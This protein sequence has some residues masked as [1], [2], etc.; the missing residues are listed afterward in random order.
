MKLLA[1]LFLTCSLLYSIEGVKN[2]NINSM[3]SDDVLKA[4]SKRLDSINL[5]VLEQNQKYDKHSAS[6]DKLRTDVSNILLAQKKLRVS[7]KKLKS[8]VHEYNGAEVK[9]KKKMDEIYSLNSQ[10][11]RTTYYVLSHKIDEEYLPSFKNYIVSKYS[12]EKFDQETEIKESTTG[13]MSYKNIVTTKKDFGQMQV[14]TLKDFTYRDIGLNIKVLKVVQSSFVKTSD[15]SLIKSVEKSVNLFEMENSTQIVELESL[16][17]IKTGILGKLQ[18]K[19]SDAKKIVSYLHTTF[20]ISKLNSNKDKSSVK[21]NK[22]LSKIEKAHDKYI[23]GLNRLSGEINSLTSQ[24]E[25]E[26]VSLALKLESANEIAKTYNIDLNTNELEKLIVLTPKVFSESVAI[27]E[28]KEFIQR[29][30]KSYLSKVNISELQQSET[31][32]NMYDLSTKNLSKQKLIEYKSIHFLPFLKGQELSVLVFGVI[33]LE[34]NIS[35]DD[36]VVKDLQYTSLEFVPV[37][38]GFKTIFASTTEVNL[39]IVKEFLETN[40]FHKYFDSYCLEDSFLPEEVKDFRDIGEEYFDYPAVCFKPEMVEEF[41]EWMSERLDKKIVL[42]SSEDWSYVAS[43]ANSSK[44][45]WG[46]ESLNEL[47]LEE[48]QPENIYYENGENTSITPVKQFSKSRIG[49]YDMCGN[50]HELVKDNGIIAIKGNSYISY[51]EESTA[52]AM[53]YEDG[54]SPA[55][56]IR[57]F[58]IKEN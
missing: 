42:V 51:I 26:K 44:F 10:L 34:D 30:L 25:D 15:N 41:M 54:L 14:E 56:G 11:K 1:I 57:A 50:V 29:K 46:N 38:K 3:D 8:L 49:M 4:V 48:L 22:T 39:G 19:S 27:G 45:C 12:I 2:I 17:K 18:I 43:N 31:L 6:I 16:K 28:E 55:T 20:D 24:V 52:L 9:Y 47:N 32:T 7:E 5:K 21:I 36:H 37:K 40:K 13:A 53:E 23:G 33:D 35:E 58:Y